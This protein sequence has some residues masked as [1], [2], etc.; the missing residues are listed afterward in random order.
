M[1][2]FQWENILKVVLLNRNYAPETEYHNTDFN[3]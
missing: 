2:K 3:E 1:L